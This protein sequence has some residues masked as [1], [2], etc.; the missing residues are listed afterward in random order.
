MMKFKHQ[1]QHRNKNSAISFTEVDR[2]GNI[3]VV[4]QFEGKSLRQ[5]NVCKSNI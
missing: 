2:F 4:V 1:R 3:A 5:E